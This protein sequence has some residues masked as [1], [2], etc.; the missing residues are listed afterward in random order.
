MG[1]DRVLSP[2][3]RD[4]REIGGRGKGEWRKKWGEGVENG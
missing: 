3:G 4:E 2:R 1:R